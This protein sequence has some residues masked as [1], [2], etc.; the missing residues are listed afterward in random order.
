MSSYLFSQNDAL[1]VDLLKQTPW[2]GVISTGDRLFKILF[3]P[4]TLIVM[5][6]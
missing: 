5:I 6:F 3:A 2:R 1:Y 4:Q